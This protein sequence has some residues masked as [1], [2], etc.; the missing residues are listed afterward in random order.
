MG[1]VTGEG[2]VGGDAGGVGRNEEDDGDG[3][4]VGSMRPEGSVQRIEAGTAGHCFEHRLHNFGKQLTNSLDA[5]CTTSLGVVA[6]A[7][8]TILALM[9]YHQQA[10]NLLWFAI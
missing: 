9:N 2:G 6:H 3:S 1:S 4:G 8:H 10:G 5:E 7:V